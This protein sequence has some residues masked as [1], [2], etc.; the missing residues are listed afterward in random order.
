MQTPQN[1]IVLQSMKAGKKGKAKIWWTTTN[2]YKTGRENIY[3]LIKTASLRKGAC[4]YT[5]K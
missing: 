2:Q 3:T 4:C 1:P 5:C